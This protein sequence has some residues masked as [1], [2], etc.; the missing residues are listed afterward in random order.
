MVYSFTVPNEYGYVILAATST[1]V[2]SIVHGVNTGKF[3]KAAGIP[4]PTAY[5]SN[6]DAKARQEAYVF[7][8]AQRAHAN[9]TENQLSVVAPLLI[10]GTRW[11]IAAAVLGGTWTLGRYLY[12]VGYCKPELGANGKGRYRG[13]IQYVGLVGLLGM[14]IWMAVEMV[15]GK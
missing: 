3:R 4:Y 7:N 13:S 2:L 1:F 8:C 10:A 11:P 15:L 6:E 12:M 14:T 9:F 5:A